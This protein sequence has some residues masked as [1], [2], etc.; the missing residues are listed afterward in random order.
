MDQMRQGQAN[1]M[2]SEKRDAARDPR[3]REEWQEAVDL[4]EAALRIDSAKK[5]GLITGGPAID[6]GRCETIL[7]QGKLRGLAPI[8]AHVERYVLAFAGAP[9]VSPGA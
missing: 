3:T 9:S 4:A 2:S 7:A 5:Y 6:V 1:W 8:E